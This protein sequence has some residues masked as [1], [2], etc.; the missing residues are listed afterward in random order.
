MNDRIKLMNQGKL[1]LGAMVYFFLTVFNFINNQYF[2]Q[3]SGDN[4]IKR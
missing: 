3:F 4:V 2:K 1:P